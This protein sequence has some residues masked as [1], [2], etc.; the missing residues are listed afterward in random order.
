M[1]SSFSTLT[2]AL[3]NIFIFLPY[4]FSVDALIGSLLSPW[5]RTV[6]RKKMVGFSFSEWGNEISYDLVSRGVGF[7]IRISTLLSYLVIQILF[8]PISL[9]VLVLYTLLIFPI[10]SLARIFSPSELQ[11]FEKERAEFVNTHTL[12]VANKNVVEKWFD[13]WYQ[14]RENSKRWFELDNLFSTVP[15]GRDWTHGYTPTLD[16][17]STDLSSIAGRHEA[18]PM[19]IGRETEMEEIEK[20]L[21]KDK[22][23][24]IIITGENGVGKTTTIESLAYRIYI[25]RGNP[26]LSFKR[27]VQINLEKVLSEAQDAKVRENILES[28]FEEAEIAGNIILVIE[29]FDKYLSSGEGRIDLST[30][31][32]KFTSSDKIHIIGLTTPS[33]YQK[34]IH[35]KEFLRSSYSV[36]ELKEISKEL[37]LK[38]LMDHSHRYESRYG[39]ILPYETLFDA[40][41][42][43][44]FFI[45]DIPFP[46]KVLQIVDDACVS[47]QNNLNI[48]KGELKIVDPSLIELII[49]SHTHTPTSLTEDFKAKLLG[50]YE[51]L[52][53]GVIGQQNALRHLTDALQRSFMLLGK[54]QKPLATFL[55]LGPTGVGKTETAKILTKEFFDDPKKMI[56]FD[57]SQ[58]QRIDDIPNL[59]GN[60]DTGEPGSL[61]SEIREQPYGILLLDEIEKA[62][63]DLLNIFLTLLDEGYI[64]DAFG[65][66][67]DCK[68]LIVIATSNAGAIEFYSKASGRSSAESNLKD[69]DSVMDFLIQ[70]KYFSPEFLNRF[71]G[72]IAFEPLSG[73]HAYT[74]AQKMISSIASEIASI[75]KVQVVVKEETIQSILKDKFNSVYGAR[76]LE[77]AISEVVENAIAQ[78]VLSSPDASGQT[79]EI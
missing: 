75:H 13:T 64:T 70:N 67:T 62:H 14:R 22:G 60:I 2:K 39:V 16:R 9:I 57:M 32:E 19:T 29:N 25:G 54:R 6:S 38:I 28:L 52:T 31:I 8:L 18:R 42:K 20:I 41:E 23:A 71:D 79:I 68:S 66:R 59:I 65:K 63:K 17:Y 53:L 1:F 35:P 43:S 78:K 73:L 15:I 24:N 56:R 10:Q 34:Y 69:S 76:N 21:C 11:K 46:E 45:N 44:S 61:I 12:D 55:F 33:A 50:I 48:P 40:V 51:K 72:V 49:S 58:F 5:K 47:T 74:I 26:L 30:P 3:V 36:F 27:L 7:T 37:A 77:R 4:F